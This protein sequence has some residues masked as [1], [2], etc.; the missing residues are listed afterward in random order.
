MND[1]SLHEPLPAQQWLTSPYY[2][3]M[4]QLVEQVIARQ[5]LRHVLMLETEAKQHF[6]CSGCAECCQRPWAVDVSKDYLEKWEA[7]FDQ[8]PS[9]YYSKPFYLT[10]E[11]SHYAEIRKKHGTHE[12]LFLEDDRRCM[13]QR[14]YGH[15]ALPTT[16]QQFPRYENWF[17]SYMG[18]FM[19]SSCP[20]VNS[21]IQTYPRMAYR[22]AIIEDKAW[23]ALQRMQHPLGTEN[24]LLWL[25]WQ[26]DLITRPGA[27]TPIE[28]LRF[29]QQQLLR[30][31]P[32]RLSQLLPQTFDLFEQ[33]LQEA[34]IR[35]ACPPSAGREA[36]ALQWLIHFTRRYSAIQKFLE[37]LRYAHRQL[38]RFS[39]E[40]QQ[41]LNQ[42]LG[43]YLFYRI[44]SLQVFRQPEGTPVFF[45][46][47]F[48]L[49]VHVA[50]W[51][52][53]VLYYRQRDGGPLQDV[54]M[55][56]AANLVGYRFE[57]DRGFALRHEMYSMAPG[58]CLEGMATLLSFDL[59]QSDKTA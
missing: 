4:Q 13:I 23:D 33:T 25:G 28:R 39:A 50:L 31:D 54:H 17:G 44:C 32:R 5:P 48:I 26:L 34:L 58:H 57:H 15:E 19:V 45:Q 51:Q 8:D 9:G 10:P 2:P 18:R 53:L 12:C 36:Q 59:G 37:Q 3:L 7:I 46:S 1:L 29:L 22:V 35:S 49:S 21:L 41:R 42:F 6:S 30:L 40:E 11:R 56:R 55:T 27:W 14:R 38:P 43:H 52:F 24:G 16:C 20:D 47:Y